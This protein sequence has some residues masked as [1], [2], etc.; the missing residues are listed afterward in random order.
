TDL[1]ILIIDKKSIS[2]LPI[3]H[4]K[5]EVI[6][7]S[8]SD[9]K[10]FISNNKNDF[11]CESIISIEN[12]LYL[13]SKDRGDNKTRV[14]KLSK[15]PGTYLISPYSEFNSRGRICG[16]SYNSSI[17]QL[18]LI[19][20]MPSTINSF[21]WIMNDFKNED[22]FEG[23]KTRIEIGKHKGN[24]KTEGIAYQSLNRLFISC[25]NTQNEKAG[26]YVYL[27]EK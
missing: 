5:A 23:T 10:K 6:Y 9:Q 14:Y 8:Y 15:T 20:Y 27:P 25:E 16:A 3:A 1:K 22:F 13:F 26:L 17:H 2:D 11:D 7:F 24:W 21:L 18:A 12:Y 4:V 19:G